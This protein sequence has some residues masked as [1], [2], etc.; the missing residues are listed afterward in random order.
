LL[1]GKSLIFLAISWRE[2]VN[3][4]SDDNEV[5]FVLD[6]YA[7][8]EFYSASSLKQ[9]SACKHVIPLRQIILIQSQLVFA[10][11]PRRSSEYQFYSLWLE[12]THDLPQSRQVPTNYTNTV[13][14]EN[15]IMICATYGLL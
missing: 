1:N 8:L 5:G 10:L 6:Q 13:P 4:Q 15:T 12:S 9:Q 3:F 14:L 7:E 11:T 2:Q